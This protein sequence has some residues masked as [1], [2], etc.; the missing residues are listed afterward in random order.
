MGFVESAIVA[1]VHTN[2][3]SCHNSTFF[4][5]YIMYFKLFSNPLGEP[6]CVSMS[7]WSSRGEPVRENAG[8]VCR[9]GSPTTPHPVF[10]CTYESWHTTT[11]CP[12]S[13]AWIGWWNGKLPQVPLSHSKVYMLYIP[14]SYCRMPKG[15]RRPGGEVIVFTIQKCLLLVLCKYC[16]MWRQECFVE[17]QKQ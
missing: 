13:S 12:Q 16:H 5:L 10:P 14:W 8:E 1:Q 2:S 7:Q 15:W 17:M 3:Q 11:W 6:R 9:T 4:T